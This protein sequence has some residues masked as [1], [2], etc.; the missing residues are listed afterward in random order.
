MCTHITIDLQCINIHKDVYTYHNGLIMYKYT[1]GCVH[2]Y[3]YQN[4][5]TMYKDTQ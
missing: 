3:T 1:Q 5:F 4:G 2:M